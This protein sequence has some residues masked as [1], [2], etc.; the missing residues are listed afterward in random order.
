MILRL[1]FLAAALCAASP[2]VAQDP[3]PIAPV[4]RYDD[5]A[6]KERLNAHMGAMF[7][8]M[9]GEIRAAMIA[10]DGDLVRAGPD[11]DLI[12]ARYRASTERMAIEVVDEAEKAARL[13][14]SR[15]AADAAPT[16]AAVEMLNANPGWILGM[17]GAGM[18]ER[19]G[20]EGPRDGVQAALDFGRQMAALTAALRSASGPEE[21]Q[22][23]LL[24]AQPGA[25]AFAGTVASVLRGNI[26]AGAADEA[27]QSA[28][29]AIAADIVRSTPDSIRNQLAEPAPPAGSA[30]ALMF[31]AQSEMLLEKLTETFTE[32]L[33][34]IAVNR[35][36]PQAAD[37]ALD[38]LVADRQPGIAALADRTLA[39]SDAW[40]TVAENDKSPDQWVMQRLWLTSMRDLTLL[41][42]RAEQE[43]ARTD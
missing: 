31:Q 4:V 23:L 34:A 41:R 40:A 21:S 6:I 15:F 29:V 9:P 20:P 38:V 27:A 16:A 42:A 26:E 36:D 24:R 28:A 2:A 13:D 3:A 18:F 25:D 22:G 12:V 10:A 35:A 14:P 1:A 39:V 30:L 8:V 17:V 37:A 33:Q 19:E 5:T 7:I 32:M 43:A 11:L